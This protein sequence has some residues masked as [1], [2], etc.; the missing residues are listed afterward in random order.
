MGELQSR[1]RPGLT[2]S[3]LQALESGTPYSASNQNASSLNGVDARPY[4]ANPGYV[5]PP[6]GA[7]TQ[8]YFTA[9][10]AFHLEGQKRTDFAAGYDYALAVG[11]N[12]RLGL[13][14][15]AQVINLFNQFQLCGCGGGGAFPLGGNIDGRNIET[16]IRTNVS[17][18]ATYQPFNPFTTTPVEGV[19]WATAP[20]FG[21]ALNRFAYTT[22]RTFRMTFG[23]KF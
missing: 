18:P 9:R 11:G 8:Y 10:D 7:N 1:V 13:F 17:T 2:L 5:N 4:L 6:D 14:F 23:V 22:P 3:V 20:G 12:R 16:G 19:H 15:Q 21:L